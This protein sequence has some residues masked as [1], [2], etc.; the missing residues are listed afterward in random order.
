MIYLGKVVGTHGIKGEVR[1]RSNFPY[2]KKAFL[3]GSTIFLGEEAFEITSYRVHKDYDMLTFKD[4]TNI[5]QVLP[6][7]GRKVY[8]TKEELSLEEEEY[9]EEELFDY[10]VVTNRGEAKLLEIVNA[11]SSNKL[12]RIELSKNV[13]LVPFQEP[14]VKV[15][16]QKKEIVITLIE[17]M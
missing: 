6:F 5:N 8:K 4:Y 1:L 10:Q 11:S 17:G 7:V 15:N 12:L 16:P 2:K 13:I 9:L 3:V 14:F